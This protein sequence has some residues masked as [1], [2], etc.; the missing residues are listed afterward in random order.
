MCLDRGLVRVF[1][2]HRL[3]CISV[4]MVL[5]AKGAEPNY[6]THPFTSTYRQTRVS[7]EQKK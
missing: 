1:H 6:Y 5:K 7:K 4:L 3:R 2:A